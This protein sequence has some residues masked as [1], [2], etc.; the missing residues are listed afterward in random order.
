[1]SSKS[2]PRKLL[3]KPGMT[4][5]TSSQELSSLVTPVPADAAEVT[6]PASAG[7]RI[8]FANSGDHLRQ[9][10]AEYGT[11]LQN[12]DVTWIAYP[13]ANKADINRDTLWPIAGEINLRPIGQVAIDE[14]WSALRFR[15]LK[16]GEAPFSPGK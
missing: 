9:L 16:E 12:D 7:V 14:T 6:D 10:L 1:M 11:A 4:W 8:L 2:V 3:I 5:W 13:K 15:P